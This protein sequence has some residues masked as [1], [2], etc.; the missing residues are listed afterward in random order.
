MKKNAMALMPR[1]HVLTSLACIVG[2]APVISAATGVRSTPTQAKG[3]SGDAPDIDATVRQRI[4]QDSE[5]VGKVAASLVDVQG[6][7]NHV[8]KEVLGKVFDMSTMK[9]FLVQ[10]EAAIKDNE[11]LSQEQSALNRQATSLSKQVEGAIKETN[12]QDQQYR[13]K[14]SSLAS[15]DAED[16]ATIQ[17]LQKAMVPLV[18]MEKEVEKLPPVNA[19]LTSQ[20]TNGIAAAQAATQELLYEKAR[21][22][23]YKDTSAKLMQ[24]LVKQHDYA[25]KCHERLYQLNT[26]IHDTESKKAASDYEEGKTSA[27]GE[28]MEKFLEQR[29]GLINARLKKSKT[30]VQTITFAKANSKSKI[31]ALQLEG[32]AQ[33]EKLKAEL[34]NLRQQAA[35]VE[36][37]M[38]AK[39]TNR[40]LIEKAIKGVNLKVEDMQRQ[41][42]AG[43]LDKL[44]RNNTQMSDDL[45]QLRQGLQKS[46]VSAA[47][48]EAERSQALAM[49]A[50]LQAQAKNQTKNVQTIASQALLQVLAVRQSADDA[51]QKAQAATMQAQASMLSKCD[52]MWDAQHPKVLQKLEDCKQVKTD[53]QSVKASVVTLAGSLQSAN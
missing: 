49:V 25:N 33:L 23:A 30:N 15:Q 41:L 8:E 40:Q 45:A 46:Q 7:L 31:S 20:N 3:L 24:E 38:M 18:E 52:S 5:K 39:I 48:A 47:K 9:T 16:K 37:A 53:L 14:M 13:A 6:D 12:V 19:K 42:L 34:G 32:Q 43:R 50:Q 17:S 4:E 27:K 35:S 29:N 51:A 1:I 22:T 2:F 21:L 28:A 26:Q 11:K 36:A 44:R 10:H